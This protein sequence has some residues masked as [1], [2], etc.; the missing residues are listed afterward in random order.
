MGNVGKLYADHV[1]DSDL[2]LLSSALGVP[3]TEVR[4]DPEC[5]PTLLADPRVFEA[6]LGERALAKGRM[7][8]VSP[9]LLFAVM[10]RRA[11]QELAFMTHVDER[12]GL[13]QRVP[14]FDTPQLVEFL[15]DP[16]RVLFLVE[17]LASFTRV[18]S[19]R[20]RVQTGRGPRWRRF[21]ELD[22]VR[23]AGL[24]DAVSEAERPGIYR[25]LGDVALFL[26]GVYPDY[27]A[28]E[29]ALSTVDATRL[30]RAA[31]VDQSLAS[32][33]S[34]ELFEYLGARWYQTAWQLTQ[35]RTER[36][37]VITE[38]AQRFRSARRVLN[39]LADRYLFPTGPAGV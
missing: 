23:L 36:L 29:R 5:L 8:E 28:G 26:T 15:A 20:Y 12:T 9:F 2:R 25:R 16:V 3:P 4:R 6:V 39:H 33:P 37:A 17:L 14:V 22:P 11:E 13:R 19:G 32:A 10:V 7:A 21:S 27:T 24:V 30:V 1:T 18:A 35:I 34:L 38:V 31:G